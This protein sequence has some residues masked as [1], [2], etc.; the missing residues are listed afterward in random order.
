[1]PTPQ[2]YMLVANADLIRRLDVIAREYLVTRYSGPGNPMN[3]EIMRLGNVIAT[4]VPFV[5]G[6][7]LMNRATGIESKDEFQE[8]ARFY[9]A[10]QQPYWVE[11][12]PATPIEVTDALITE[13]FKVTSSAS[14]LYASPLPSTTPHE[15]D[16]IEVGESELTTFLDTINI[17]FGMPDTVLEGMRANQSFWKQ[18]DH[19]HLFLARIDG[20]PVGAAM[21]SMQDDAG[22]LAAASTLPE[23]RHRGVQTA[24]LATR[25]EKARAQGAKLVTGQAEWGGSSQ[26][27]MQR[28]GL[29]ISH[30]RVLWTNQHNHT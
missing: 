1:M 16:I 11:V 13:D 6:N 3:A 15:I 22:Y 9:T 23:F 30:V 27:N 10:T 2:K 19:W 25:I 5:P 18:V 14:S 20:V 8:V 17:G 28:A 4:K 24:L 29:Q 7:P 26:G 21:L 12:T